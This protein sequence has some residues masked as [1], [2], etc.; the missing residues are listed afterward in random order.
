M[1]KEAVCLLSVSCRR[2]YWVAKRNLFF[3]DF[4]LDHLEATSMRAHLYTTSQT[5]ANMSAE[6]GPSSAKSE[7]PYLAHMN[8]APQSSTKNPLN[9]LVPRRV[10]VQQAK[11]IMVSTP[12]M[13]EL[14]IRTETSTLSRASHRSRVDTKRFSLVERTSRCT[15]RWRSSCP[16][17]TRTRLQ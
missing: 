5:P 9:G 11:N 2:A 12:S 4:A 14:T 3:S 10:T 8:P 6:A 17:S 15:K 16:C 1:I 13:K 7:N